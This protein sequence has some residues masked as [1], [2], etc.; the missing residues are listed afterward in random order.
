[1]NSRDRHGRKAFH[2]LLRSQRGFTLI[3]VLVVAVTMIL[4][5]LIVAPRIFGWIDEG[6]S[7][8]AQGDAA[9]LAVAMN[10]FFQHTS[11]W[12]GQVEILRSNSSKRFLIVGDP[13]K[14]TFPTMDGS[15]G[16]GAVTCTRGLQGVTSNVTAFAAAVPSSTNTVDIMDFILRKPSASDYPNWQGPY[17]S[18][19]VR[20]D[21]WNRA[22]VI[23]VIP[24]FCEETVT[25]SDAAGK[26]GYAW[27]L[28]AGPNGTLQ[29][30]FTAT[31]LS[32]D[33]DD[34]GF[35]VGKR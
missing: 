35:N 10:R 31:K 9:A 17:L 15:S 3:E 7:V 22:W 26:A 14:A 21:P 8:K 28:S 2:P 11:R 4:L 16:I 29:T 6:R 12:P 32:P 23:N 24:L 18:V 13:A 5:G 1:M 27:I 20:S 19:E 33:A 30:K 25:A 34:A